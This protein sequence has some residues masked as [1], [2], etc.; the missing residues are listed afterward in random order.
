VAAN[1]G[2]FGPLYWIDDNRV[3]FIGAKPA[4]PRQAAPKPG[5]RHS[6]LRLHVWDLRRNQV[7]VHHDADLTYGNVCVRDQYV[8]V[9]YGIRNDEK[10]EWRNFVFA[11]PFGQEKLSESNPQA[12]LRILQG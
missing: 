1:P 3:L 6:E 12:L 2:G 4:T 8:V 11:G 5:E 7:A 10:D 9:R